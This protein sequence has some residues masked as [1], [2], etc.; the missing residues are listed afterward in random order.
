MNRLDEEVGPAYWRDEYHETALGVVCTLSIWT[1]GEWVGKT[2]I[3]TDSDIEGEKGAYS[4]AFKRAAVK[5]GIGRELYGDGTASL[6]DDSEEPDSAWQLSE[7]EQDRLEETGP[8]AKR[9]HLIEAVRKEFNMTKKLTVT[10]LAAGV[11]DGYL[12]DD[13]DNLKVFSILRKRAADK[14]REAEEAD[15]KA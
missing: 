9:K 4:D 11:A 1:D 12:D 5:W 2:D 13:M 8:L 3:G 6:D 10:A 15:P 14:A 7:E